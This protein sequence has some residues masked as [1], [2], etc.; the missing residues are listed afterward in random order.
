MFASGRLQD[1]SAIGISS[2]KKTLRAAEQDRPDVQRQREQWRLRIAEVDPSRF[3]FIDESGAK[4]NM[5][6]LR[7]R[8]KG[9]GRLNDS[10]PLGHWETTTMI[11]ALR[12][13]GPA[14]AMVIEGATDAAV[15]RAYVK[16]VLVPAL[17]P[18]EIV[19]LDNLSSHKGDEI[20]R[21]I[22]AVGC[23]L[24]LLPPYSPDLNPIEKM[25]SKVKEFLRAAKARCTE[26]LDRA[27]A[28][29]LEKVQPQDAIGW[30]ESCG[31]RYD[32]S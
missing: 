27:V 25:W 4:T 5:T 8:C 16:H 18:G 2:Q 23:E 26:E 19:V 31:Y 10:T 21:M 14:A 28:A 15:F 7:G 20:R 11:A 29:G 30:F 22:E 17:R 1:A 24:W 32:K 3:V 13:D 12:L 6:R 9:G